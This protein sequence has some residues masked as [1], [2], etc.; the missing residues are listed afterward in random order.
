M[1]KA[2]KVLTH[3]V[4]SFNAVHSEALV[5]L[6]ARAFVVYVVDLA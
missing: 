6:P 1:P 5:F 3:G 2:E 4:T